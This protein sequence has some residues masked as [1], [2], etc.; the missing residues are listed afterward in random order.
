LSH[1]K[2]KGQTIRK[3][4]GG[5]S[6]SSVHDLFIFFPKIVGE[7][8]GEVVKNFFQDV[9]VFSGHKKRVKKVFPD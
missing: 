7:R 4:M 8:G 6:I 3:V 2:A 1:F 9:K 5:W